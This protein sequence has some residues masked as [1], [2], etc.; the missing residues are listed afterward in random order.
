EEIIKT[1]N[2]VVVGKTTEKITN[3]H[4]KAAVTAIQLTTTPETCKEIVSEQKKDGR[5]E[6][7]E[8]IQKEL[9]I[10]STETL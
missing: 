8:T 10:P 2:K 5:I 6:L 4:K 1:S 3:E 7:S 9:G